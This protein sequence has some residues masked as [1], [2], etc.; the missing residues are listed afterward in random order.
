[1]CGLL[2]LIHK[3][4]QCHCCIYTEWTCRIQNK[5][6]NILNSWATTSVQKRTLL[7]GAT[8]FLRHLNWVKRNSMPS[9]RSV[10]STSI[11]VYLLSPWRRRHI[12]LRNIDNH[13][14]GVISQKRMAFIFFISAFFLYFFPFLF[15]F[16]TPLWMVFSNSGIYKFLHY[17]QIHNSTIMY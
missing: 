4:N 8:L 16:K 2:H 7:S 12:F 14:H 1:M 15:S 11:H 3:K 13:L 10:V 5:T 17:Q 6:G 9:T